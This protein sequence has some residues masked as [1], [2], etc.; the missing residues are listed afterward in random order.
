M[1]INTSRIF[2][3]LLTIALFAGL[4]SSCSAVKNKTDM[5]SPDLS[6][7]VGKGVPSADGGVAYDNSTANGGSG[8]S[9]GAPATGAYEQ[10]GK[11]S[12][13]TTTPPSVPDTRKIIKA[14]TLELETL[15]FNDAVAQITSLAAAKGGYVEYSYVSGESMESSETERHANFTIRIPASVLDEYVN[16][17][18]GSFNV[19]SK[20]ENSSDI[21]D[22]YYDAEAHLNSLK[23]QEER[24][25]SMLEGATELQYM[26]QVEQTLADVRYQ[27]ESYY[28]TIKRY[29]SQVS[30]STV[31]INLYEVIKY[32]D[33]TEKPKTYSERI[34]QALKESWK[35]FV[36]GWKD[37]SVNFI[38]AIPT[39]LFIAVLAVVV[40]F[41][42]RHSSKKRRRKK[43]EADN[44]K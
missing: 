20:T 1:K 6:G 19:L 44:K 24:L 10:P 16:G 25:L 42:I 7:E 13:I 39:L 5:V 38:Y 40:I 31:S 21:T 2:A 36:E 32:K 26:L 8:V 12:V 34:G 18:S 22:V 14:V 3:L 17:L 43:D 11:V 33:I 23:T 29:D 30:L 41:I 9:Q 15:V 4:F 27:I 37:F 35:N 28:S